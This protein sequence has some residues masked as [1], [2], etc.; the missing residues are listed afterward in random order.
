MI[1][2]CTEANMKELYIYMYREQLCHK[3]ECTEDL[4]LTI[5]NFILS[6]KMGYSDEQ[7]L[8]CGT[9]ECEW[10]SICMHVLLYTYCNSHM[11]YTLLS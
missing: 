7:I 8:T 4:K 10:F 5:D 3:L 9:A 11:V 1:I 6:S 2:L